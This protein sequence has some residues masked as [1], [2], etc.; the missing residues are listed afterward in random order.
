MA[1]PVGPKKVHHDRLPHDE[2]GRHQ[3]HRVPVLPEPAAPFV[4]PP[5]Q[6]SMPIRHGDKEATVSTSRSRRTVRRSA[7]SRIHTVQ[8]KR[9]LCQVNAHGSNLF[10]DF[11]SGY[12]D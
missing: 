8:R 3:P 9:V 6:A 1:A 2:L 12:S 10:H 5:E 11:S 7:V 4:R